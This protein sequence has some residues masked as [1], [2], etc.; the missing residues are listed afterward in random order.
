[1]TDQRLNNR[2]RY[3]PIKPKYRHATSSWF[4]KIMADAENRRNGKE[5]QF[6]DRISNLLLSDK[7]LNDEFMKKV[8]PKI[9]G[10]YADEVEK[11]S[12]IFQKEYSELMAHDIWYAS[13]IW[14]YDI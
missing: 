8:W 3:Y 1:M 5:K 2:V 6:S 10:Q 4:A 12:E 11:N 9:I 14:S 7:I 13:A